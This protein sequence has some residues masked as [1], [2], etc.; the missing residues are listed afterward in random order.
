ML[1]SFRVITEKRADGRVETEA[2]VKLVHD[3]E[4]LVAHRARATARSTRS[5]ARCARPSSRACPELGDI[6]LVNF[7]V[8]IL[9]ETKG[10]GA[11]HPRAHRLQRRPRHWGA[12]GVSENVI[13]ASWEALVDSLEHG[14]RRPSRASRAP[15][16]ASSTGPRRARSPS[17]SRSSATASAELVDARCS[18]SGQLSLGPMVPRFERALVRAHRRRRTPSPAP[19]APPACTAACTRWASAPATRSS[20]RRSRSSPP[21]TRS[22]SPARRRCS[23]RSTRSRFNMDPAAVEAAIT[24]RTKA[25]LIVDIFGYP[26]D[27]PALVEIAERARPGAASRTPARPSTATT[28]A[29]KLGTFGHPAVYGFYANK[30]LTTAEGGVVLT[31]DAALA[32]MLREPGATRGARTTAPG[33]SHSRLGFNY[34]LSDVHSAIGVAQL[35]RLDDIMAGRARVARL[36]P[37]ARG[38]PSTAS[39]RCTRARSARSW[40]VY[41]P[42]LDPGPRPRRGDRRPRRRRRLGQAV[43]A[44][45]PPAALLPGRRTATGPAIFPVTE[46]ISASTIALP[47]FPEMTEDQ[48]DR[49]VRR[50][51]PLAGA[52]A[53]LGGS[54][55]G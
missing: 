32:S 28:T 48:V 47:F 24:P 39:R 9:D 11:V 12:I 5:T 18:R 55:G 7:K 19:A 44:L 46:A 16:A 29:R 21:P 37:G 15:P 31:D 6:E 52:P 25:I 20:R 38:R 51:R 49:V 54:G 30:Q 36:V 53:P 22:C 14:V 35:E 42:R 27:V 41:A 10:T 34:R 3:G 33:S 23:P 4:R 17:P 1:E 13:E 40:F 26:A 50:A 8:R 45:H 2:T 43:P